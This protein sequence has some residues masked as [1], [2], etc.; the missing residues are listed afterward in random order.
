[1]VCLISWKLAVTVPS[2][3]ACVMVVVALLS[4]ARVMPVVAVQFTNSY[5]V[6]GVAVI[7]PEG[8]TT[9]AVVEEG[10]TVPWLALLDSIVI[11]R[12]ISVKFAVTVPAAVAVTAVEA[13]L[14]S[15]TVAP[16][17]VVHW[18]NW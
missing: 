15:A 1:M 13:L 2:A 3:V 18:L 14:A 8:V 7:S 10:L 12:I 16:P 4:S 6:F 5:P 9:P 17:V 11:V